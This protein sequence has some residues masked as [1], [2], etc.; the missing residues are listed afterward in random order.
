MS[1]QNYMA[2]H[3]NDVDIFQF[4]TKVATKRPT[5]PSVELKNKKKTEKKTK[6]REMGSYK[7]A[8]G[9]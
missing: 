1:V 4:W 5:L 8:R 7:R 2:I 3:L 9:E 6:E